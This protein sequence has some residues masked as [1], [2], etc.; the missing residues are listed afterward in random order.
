MQ[1]PSTWESLLIGALVILIVFWMRP[2]IKAAIVRSRQAKPDWRAVL[3][4][5][6]LV[7]LFVMLLA[8]LV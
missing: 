2:G 6:A 4:L 5:L 8:A 3:M 1:P 7:I